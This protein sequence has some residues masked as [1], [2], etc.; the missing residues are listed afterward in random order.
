[1]KKIKIFLILSACF[2]SMVAYSQ[3]D[4]IYNRYKHYYYT[5]WYDSCYAAGAVCDYIGDLEPV[6]PCVG[7]F[8][9]SGS[10]RGVYNYTATPLQIIGVVGGII[11]TEYTD[12]TRLPEYFM[13]F[14]DINGEWTLVDSARW[15][16]SKVKYLALETR[17]IKLRYR[18]VINGQD[19]I[20][21]AYYDTMENVKYMKI[22]EAYF[23]SPITVNDSF[24]LSGTS[25]NN[26]RPEYGEPEYDCAGYIHEP[27]EYTSSVF[28]NCNRYSPHWQY[29]DGQWQKSRNNEYNGYYFAIF[30]II[31]VLDTFEIIGMS[32]DE[33][34][35]RVEGSGEYV[36]NS[37]VVLTAIPNEGYDFEM[38]NDGVTDNPRV[39]YAE[40]DTTFTAYFA[41][42]RQYTV[43]V[44]SAD[45]SQGRVA[46]GGTF[47]KNTEIDIA[48][49]GNPGYKFKMW[50]DSITDNPRTIVVTQDTLFTAYF[51]VKVGISEAENNTE[52]FTISPNP[53]TNNLQIN[54]AQQGNYTL[55]IYSTNGTMLR[56][57]QITHS[58]TIDVS[59]LVAGNYFI[60]IYNATTTGIRAFVKQ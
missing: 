47:D 41:P 54:I 38:W 44:L 8:S 46:G 3:T 18:E 26:V 7:S 20:V 57:K 2:F 58:S 53:A 40:Q 56:Q 1:M 22:C 31:E 33:S 28:A 50:N 11:R 14:D 34:L 49:Q 35:G 13:V 27:T 4:T 15:D 55:E 43:E 29:S 17:L 39:I 23:K 60:K 30:P 9:G 37:R 59:T 16:T 19:T 5:S 42:I 10:M 36:K 45:L 6:N 51:E 12:T 21:E 24:L 32:H 52:L 25:F 48:A